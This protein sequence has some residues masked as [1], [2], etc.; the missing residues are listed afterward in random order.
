M[1]CSW[2]G[3]EYSLWV[4]LVRAATPLFC[5]SWK[6]LCVCVCFCIITTDEGG[7]TLASPGESAPELER[8]TSTE[9]VVPDLSR[10]ED[11]ASWF[12]MGPG[13]FSRNPENFAFINLKD[14]L[15]N[16]EWVCYES[17]HTHTHTLITHT[18]HTH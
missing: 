13:G 11:L 1:H 17:N 7:A 6:T 15:S 14:Y 12:K 8:A 18:D 9:Q 10:V 2:N 3:N 5:S 4:F 16:I